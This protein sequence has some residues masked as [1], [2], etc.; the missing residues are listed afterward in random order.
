MVLTMSNS[1]YT[2]HLHAFHGPMDLLLYLI[3][4]SEVDVIDI[5]I[6]EITD[7]YL[8][9]LKNME[10]IDIEQAGDFLIMAATL[11]EIKSR[12]LV[13]PEDNAENGNGDGAA[14]MM[15]VDPLTGLNQADPRYE[16]IQQLLAYKKFRDAAENL[17]IRRIDW[18]AQ[19]PIHPAG[20]SNTISG[21]SEDNDHIDNDNNEPLETDIED[22]GVWDLFSIFQRIIEAVDFNRLGEHQVEYDD[23]PISLHQ[24]D[25]IDQLKR[26]D[27][28]TLS[29]R[30]ILFQR[31]RGEMLGL[32]LATLELVKLCSITIT[33]DRPSDDIIIRLIETDNPDNT[34]YDNKTADNTD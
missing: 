12:M 4:K 13:P 18:E 19:F 24:E 31:T 26:N 33:Q 20:S 14:G 7:Q 6:A 32:F 30:K 3:R 17:N 28:H 10:Q 27:D 22:V 1:D 21:K 5:P 2:I 25:I 29:F 8:S 11:M 16:L 15:G 9:F 23:T 34:E